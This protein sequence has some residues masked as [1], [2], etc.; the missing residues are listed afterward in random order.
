MRLARIL[1]IAV[2]VY[3]GI[4]T[5]FESLIGVLQPASG[6]TLVITTFDP[7]GTAHDRVVSRLGSEGRVYVA[8][9]HW[10]RAWY[11]RALANPDVQATIAGAKADYRAVPVSGAE[12][13]R[14]NGEHALPL[15]F[16]F[17]T[18]FPPRLL[19]R[20]DPR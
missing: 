2:V 14:V 10:P 5:A 11:R 13:D 19:V 8:A 17:L 18:G 4:V 15:A 12:H 1:L 3:V 16:R 6:D 7:D 20:L 9:N